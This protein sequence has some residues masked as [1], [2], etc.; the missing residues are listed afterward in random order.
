MAELFPSM[1]KGLALTFHAQ[2]KKEGLLGGRCFGSRQR[3]GVSVPTSEHQEDCHCLW[4]VMADRQA[5][6][7][8]N[9]QQQLCHAC[10]KSAGRQQKWGRLP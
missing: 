3:S 4:G 1:G 9:T 6:C 5:A 10:R 2:T 8:P 7:P